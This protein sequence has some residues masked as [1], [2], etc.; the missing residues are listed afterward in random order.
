MIIPAVYIDMGA[1]HGFHL[2]NE[3]DYDGRFIGPLFIAQEYSLHLSDSMSRLQ[4]R[5][6]LTGNGLHCTNFSWSASVFLL[7]YTQWV[8]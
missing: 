5:N 2:P 4:L 7:T 8:H 1:W 6:L 3:P